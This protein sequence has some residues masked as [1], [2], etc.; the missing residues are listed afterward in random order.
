MEWPTS[1]SWYP[2]EHGDGA[3]ARKHYDHGSD[4][5]EEELEDPRKQNPD[6]KLEAGENVTIDNK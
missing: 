2:Q 3:R 6:P 1:K 5:E 4:D